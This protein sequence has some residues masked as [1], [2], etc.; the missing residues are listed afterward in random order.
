VDYILFS[1][2]LLWDF[3]LR[4]MHYYLLYFDIFCFSSPVNFV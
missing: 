2:V 3:S 4:Y 1:S